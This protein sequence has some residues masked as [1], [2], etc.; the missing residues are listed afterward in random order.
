MAHP[1]HRGFTMI[2]TFEAL[3]ALHSKT[4]QESEDFSLLVRFLL[5]WESAKVSHKRVFALL[6]PEIRS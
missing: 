4:P 5:I 3:K 1:P 6:T 2:L